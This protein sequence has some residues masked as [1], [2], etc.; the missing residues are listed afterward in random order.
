MLSPELDPASAP[1]IRSWLDQWK[2]RLPEAPVARQRLAEVSRSHAPLVEAELDAWL[3][4]E[5]GLIETSAEELPWFDLLVTRW[6]AAERAAFDGD[7]VSCSYDDLYRITAVRARAWRAAGVAAGSTVMVC[8]P[9]GYELVVDLFTAFRIGAIAAWVP[10]YGEPYERAAL[11]ACKAEFARF[12]PAVLRRLGSPEAATLLVDEPWHR[13]PLAASDEATA[14]YARGAPCLA[15]L[16]PTAASPDGDVP[17]WQWAPLACDALLR[18]TA[19]DAALVWG[20]RPGDALGAPGFDGPRHQPSLLL[21]C[22]L[23]GACYVHRTRER[24]AKDPACLRRDWRALG[25]RPGLVEPSLA[26]LAQGARIDACFRDLEDAWDPALWH[27]FRARLP[28]DT[29]TLAVFV[30]PALGG[31]ALGAYADAGDADASVHVLPGVRAQ[32]APPEGA[33]PTSRLGVLSL[34]SAPTVPPYALLW[35]LDEA[36][37]RYVGTSG[38][39]RSGCVMPRDVLVEAVRGLPGVGAASVVA[40]PEGAPEGGACFGLVVFVHSPAQWSDERA[41]RVRQAVEKFLAEVLAPEVRPDFVEC[42]P[43]CL[44]YEDAPIG[45][46]WITEQWV[47]GTLKKKARLSVFRRLAALQAGGA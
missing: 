33:P 18:A 7:G 38:P 24:A 5:L 27:R 34:E 25:V 46:S 6:R 37:Y 10:A 4:S 1:P 30:E 11:G 43:L 15:V 32:V 26:A 22:L 23:A 17:S 14:A 20:L 29:E 42:Y 40:L 39:R 35:R 19:R 31:A 9:F 13:A 45:A 12:D 47:R 21:A 44:P 3:A 2:R 36:R 8:R 16:S 41:M 28:S